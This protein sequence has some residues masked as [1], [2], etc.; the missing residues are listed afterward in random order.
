MKRWVDNGGL[1]VATSALGTG[2]NYSGIVYVLHIGVHP[3][4]MLLAAENAYNELTKLI[5]E[6]DIEKYNVRIKY[7]WL[8]YRSF[9]VIFYATLK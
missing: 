7:E 8:H 1:I 3:Y 9:I 6:A 5:N 4:D 2:V